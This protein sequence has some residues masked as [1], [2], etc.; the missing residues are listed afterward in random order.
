MS[1]Y[2][3]HRTGTS[4][5]PVPMPLAMVE[6]PYRGDIQR[7]HAYLQRLIRHVCLDLGYAPM[8]SH[9]MMT[10][11]LDDNLAGERRLGI[12]AGYAWAHRADLAFFGMDYG[13][14]TGMTAAYEYYKTIGLEC[15]NLKIG[16]NDAE[17]VEEAG[18]NDGRS[19]PQSKV[20]Q[21]DGDTPERGEGV[22]RR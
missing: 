1:Y 9:Q 16:E 2:E 15:I 22:Q 5:L 17:H 18:P 19:R 20:R 3:L 14:S 7:N 4:L 12:T 6:S 11:A 13:V 21:E 8:A 10:S